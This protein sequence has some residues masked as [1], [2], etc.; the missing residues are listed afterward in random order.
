MDNQTKQRVAVYV[1]GLNLYH[2]LDSWGKA[3]VIFLFFH[4]PVKFFPWQKDS[5]GFL[6]KK[7]KPMLN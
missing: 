5:I 1:D 2:A 4:I 7:K 3:E 6:L